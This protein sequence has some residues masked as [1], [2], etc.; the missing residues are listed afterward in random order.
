MTQVIEHRTIETGVVRL[1]SIARETSK[2]QSVTASYSVESK[3]ASMNG[4][5]RESLSTPAEEILDRPLGDSDHVRVII[6]GA[7]A[8]GLNMIRTMRKHLVNFE[9]V[10]YEKNPEVGGTWYEN[11]Y[12]GCKCDI[13]SHNYQFSWHLNPK[14]SGFFAGAPE[15]E[16]YLLSLTE[17]EQL[18][19][20]IQLSHQ[21]IHAEWKEDQTQWLITVKNLVTGDV[22]HDHC[23]FFLNAGGIL[24]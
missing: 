2:D 6:V 20:C 24:K 14:W 17:A 11:R 21:I 8:S 1:K 5:D 10:V 16:Q 19:T 22:F 7:G 9:M 18:K 13:P 23:N 12:P 15:I 3:S 4:R